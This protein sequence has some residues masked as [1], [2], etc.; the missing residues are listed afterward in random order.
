MKIQ[1]KIY[2]IGYFMYFKPRNTL[3]I[4]Q[5]LKISVEVKKANS[6]KI[7]ELAINNIVFYL[8]S[9]TDTD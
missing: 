2:N 4:D 6:C 3:T 5:P 8:S 1:E 7:K 9:I